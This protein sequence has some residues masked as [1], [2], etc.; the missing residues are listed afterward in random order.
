MIQY[1]S[2]PFKWF[3][4]LEAASGLVLLFAAVIAL[5]ISN[6]DLSNAYFD[7]L[8]SYLKL[9]VGIFS[10]KLSVLHWINDV[11]MAIFFF[12][13]SLEIKREFIQGELS[14]PKQALLPIVAAVGGMVVPALIYIAINFK[15]PVTLK[16][17]AIPSATDIAFS[18][19]VLSL[20]GKRVPLSLKVFLTAL[21]IIDDL[22]AIVIIAFFYSG[23]VQYF[24]LLLM[25]GCLIEKLK[26]ENIYN[27]WRHVHATQNSYGDHDIEDLGKPLS[28]S[29]TLLSKKA[30]EK[31]GGYEIQYKTNGEDSNFCQKLI[32]EN[33][34]ISYSSKAKCYHLRNDSLKSL[35]DASRRGYIYGA[36]LKKPT[37]MRFLQRS[38]RH[39]KG[40]FRNAFKD[41]IK[42]RFSLIYVGFRICINHINKEF[43]GFIK[44]KSDYV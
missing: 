38:I 3:F 26:N 30:W 35:A 42:F 4:K 36:G 28:G 10:L 24:Y 32:N 33:F 37:F 17:W 41:I 11:L 7:I 44:K 16:G 6:S 1:I 43:V 34:K 22:G 12:L 31:V 23:E 8:N 15:D 2:K 5:I 21:A 13:V 25:L 18:L 19:G 9:G 20:L 14:N 40:F 27:M 39:L 29:N